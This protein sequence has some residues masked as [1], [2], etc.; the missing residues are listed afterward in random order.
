MERYSDTAC[1]ADRQRNDDA[2]TGRDF[3]MTK[4][5]LSGSQPGR[6]ILRTVAADL[7]DDRKVDVLIGYEA[8][9]LPLSTTPLIIDSA[10]PDAL[11]KAEALI[12]DAAAR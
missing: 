1:S 4:N 9:T 12:F 5:V 6:G 7:L 11:R 2:G 3:S 8:G 10:D